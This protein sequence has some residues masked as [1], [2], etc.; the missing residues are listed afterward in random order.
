MLNALCKALPQSERLALV[1]HIITRLRVDPRQFV[2][3]WDGFRPIEPEELRQL[4]QF[5]IAVGAHTCSHGIM[6]RMT[7]PEQEYELRESK[8]LIESITGAACDQFAY[9]N[10]GPGDF[11]ADTRQCVI[12]AGYRSAFTTIKRRVSP[13]EDRFEIPR[14][15]L[16]HNHMSLAEF[17]AE[18]SGLPGTLRALLN[19]P[20][21]RTDARRASTPRSAALTT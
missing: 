13:V 11:S 17:S 16:T 18:L 4:P 7:A 2:A 6:A 12:D 3:A 9:P 14:C 20:G 1:D 21:A 19:R 10:G 5:G 8:R 15:T